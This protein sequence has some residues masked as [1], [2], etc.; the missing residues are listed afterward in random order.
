MQYSPIRWGLIALATVVIG[1]PTVFYAAKGT[2]PRRT[3]RSA[4]S[5][6]RVNAPALDPIAL[7]R[8]GIT[9]RLNTCMRARTS[10][11]KERC[12]VRE[13]QKCDQ[14]SS[15]KTWCVQRTLVGKLSGTATTC[16]AEQSVSG[17]RRCLKRLWANEKTA[18]RRTL[19]NTDRKEVCASF[20][21]QTDRDNCLMAAVRQF[22]RDGET[23]RLLCQQIQDV[24]LRDDCSDA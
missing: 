11:E 8:K 3:T 7:K 4:V 13:H 20:T 12:Y 14:E 5:A 6:P 21:T 17:K 10:Q 1:A 16:G 23:D 24:D 2:P 15:E 19:T 18:D 22:K 9:D